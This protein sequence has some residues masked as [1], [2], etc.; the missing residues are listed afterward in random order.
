MHE[1]IVKMADKLIE[2]AV[3]TYC[4]NGDDYTDWDLP[5]LTQYLGTPVHPHWLLQGA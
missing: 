2:E 1:T 4:G 5:G 3:A